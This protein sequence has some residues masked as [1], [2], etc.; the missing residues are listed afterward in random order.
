MFTYVYPLYPLYVQICVYVYPFPSAPNILDTIS[1]IPCQS[2]LLLGI[3][4]QH[5]WGTSGCGN[6]SFMISL[7]WCNC[8]CCL[9]VLQKLFNREPHCLQP[10]LNFTHSWWQEKYHLQ[11]QYCIS[12]NI[13]TMNW[14]KHITNLF[15]S[16]K[17]T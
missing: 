10:K 11:L 6:S 17:V 13:Q 14:Q 9:M 7:L 4:F 3:L 1:R 15:I 16:N 2:F 8:N 5:I 12:Y